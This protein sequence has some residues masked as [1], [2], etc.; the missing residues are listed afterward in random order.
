MD[1]LSLTSFFSDGAAFWWWLGLCLTL[2]L[3]EMATMSLFL[4]WP[5]LAAA[6]VAVIVYIV[7]GLGLA[8]QLIVFA[9]ISVALTYLGRSYFSS[10]LGQEESDRPMLNQRGAQMIGRQVTA[11]RDFENGVGSVQIDD[12]QWRARLADAASGAEISSGAVLTVSDI[13]GVTLVVAPR[14]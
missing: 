3:V 14:D 7:P 13:D 4:L 11:L 10:S 6:L 12:G 9:I 2:I 5:G 1:G 8:P